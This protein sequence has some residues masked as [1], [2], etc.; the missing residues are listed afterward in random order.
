[1][2]AVGIVAEYNPFH[3]G[4]AYHIEQTKKMFD[5]D[6]AIVCVMSGNFV[7][8]GEAASFSKFARA[9]AAVRSSADLVLELP[10][11]WSLSS[12][13]GF[14]GGAVAALAATGVVDTISFGSEEGSIAGLEHC[15]RALLDSD[16]DEHIKLRLDTGIS[17]ASARQLAL[18]EKFGA[19]AELI[20]KPN[21][22]LAI[23]Y[24]KSIILLD[25]NIEPVTIKRRGA[26]HDEMAGGE[27]PSASF[28]RSKLALG[29]S[30]KGCVPDETLEV[31]EQEILQGRGPVT[32]ES[33]EIALL[34]R[35]RMLDVNNFKKIPDASDGAG[36]RLYNALQNGVSIESILYEAKTKRYAMSRLRRMLMCAVLEVTADIKDS[37][38]PY[39]RVLAANEKGRALLRDMTSMATLP[40]ITK[41]SAVNSLSEECRKLF[42]LESRATDLF[43]LGYRTIE[44]RKSGSDYR[45]SP[46][47]I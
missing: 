3:N 15:A 44:E 27:M 19:A 38:L 18:K 43:V 31:F 4:H 40:I 46:F 1:M 41:P 22:I 35:L 26:P 11:P 28:L 32:M 30:L 9:K 29:E 20:A 36:N 47:M 21:N 23:E 14:A 39:L 17:Y 8:R 42:D 10:L 45:T 5:E 33:L 7:Q 25:L 13:E 12:A 6:T 34:S 2:K 24:I 16:I 37:P